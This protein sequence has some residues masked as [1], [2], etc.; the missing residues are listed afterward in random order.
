MLVKSSTEL[1][2]CQRIGHDIFTLLSEKSLW[3]SWE[4]SKLFIHGTYKEKNI[5]FL[6]HDSF[7]I[8]GSG[9]NV[10]ENIGKLNNM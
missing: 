6:F 5:V 9:L 2:W 1:L 3:E 4:K 7:P 10:I 8:H